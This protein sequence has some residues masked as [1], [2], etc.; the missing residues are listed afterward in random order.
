MKKKEIIIILLA[1]LSVFVACKKENDLGQV[2]F[3][4]PVGA[5]ALVADSNAILASWLK[6]QGASSYTIQV[7]RDTFRTIDQSVVVSD[8]GRVL[9]KDLQWD[10]LYQVQVRANA[11]DTAFSSRWSSL[12]AIKTPRFPTILTSPAIG[13]IT[14]TA[15]K[16][17]WTSSGATVTSVKIL[18]ASDSSV[19][20]TVALLPADVTAQS[21]IVN[22]LTAATPYIIFLYSGANV[23]GW[24]NFS[25]KAPYSGTVI[26]LTGITG[27]PSVLADT[28]PLIPS[29]S[30]VVL[31]RGE[32]YNIAAA[33]NFSKT[34]TIV[35]GGDL[36]VPGQAVITMPSNFNVTS[37]SVIDSIIFND[38][39]LRGTDYTAKYVFNIDK[40]CTIGKMS[41][42]GCRAEIFRGVVRLQSQ[43]A[44]V[45]NFLVDNCI[46]DSLA[47]YGLINVDNVVAKA[48]NITIRNTTIY[49]AQLIVVSKNN[50]NSVTIENCTI[51]EAPNGGGSSYYIDYSTLNVTNGIIINNSIF[52]LGKVNGA[53]QTVRGIRA[54]TA[55][56]ISAANNYRTSDQ[57]S[58]GNDIPNIITYT[59]PSAQL[60]QD[61]ANGNFKIID[62]SFP[63]RNT[64]GDPRWRIQ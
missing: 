28:I 38:V 57:V 26:N 42:I 20:T 48:D 3:F 22:G 64:T 25:T 29:G 36:T 15:V 19:V 7:S 32:N 39:T 49:K 58:L 13:D 56:P 45:N 34:I 31:K 60:W 52:G 12:G 43:P 46:V 54:G 21:K 24:V 8:T 27:R 41:F 51:N 35:S 47:G 16:V 18:K 2:R 10:K 61:P 5:A 23:R 33:I 9:V 4:R 14:E 59:R 37:G 1:L 17:S 53:A 63:G 6:I 55:T 40:A 11:A 62:A 50:S 44:I 30:T